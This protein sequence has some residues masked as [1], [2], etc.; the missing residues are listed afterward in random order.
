MSTSSCRCR[1]REMT[2]TDDRTT[3]LVVDDHALVRAGL[4]EIISAERDMVVVGEAGDSA[5]AVQL[6][7]QMR[8]RV[9]LLDVEIPGDDATTTVS[10]IHRISPQSRV[11]VVSMYEGPLLLRSL[12]AA[13]I[14]GYLL[15][16]AC[17]QELLLAIRSA[18]RNGPVVLKVSPQSLAL[19]P[20]P[21]SQARLSEREREV[22]GYVA[23]ALSNAEIAKRMSVSE[24]TVKRHLRSTFQKLGAVSRIDAVNKAV[25]ASLI[26]L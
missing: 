23:Q 15:K 7:G 6:T 12:L 16:S 17:R 20:R 1:G 4:R 19:L 10:N 14:Q 22:L 5:R 9:V 8:P 25:D 26:T 13:G 21:P 24:E 18:S 3:V 11:V 2:P